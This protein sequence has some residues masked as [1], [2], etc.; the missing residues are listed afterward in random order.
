ML[1][2]TLL[3]I[4]LCISI[5]AYADDQNWTENSISVKQPNGISFSLANEIKYRSW[6]WN[7]GVFTKNWVFGVGKKLGNGFSI[8]LNYKQELTRS[9]TGNDVLERRPNFDISWKKGL[10][11]RSAFDLRLRTEI[12]KYDNGLKSDQY[13]FRF[14]FRFTVQ[15]SILGH[16]VEPYLA[17]EPFYDTTSDSLSKYRFSTGLTVPI[18]RHTKLRLGYLLE[19]AR[20]GP[21]HHVFTT[22][23]SLSF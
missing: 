11:N 18:I 13:R 5:S 15:R 10:S 19:E 1:R 7:D 6:N 17:I 23:V 21:T 22:G 20:R 9:S 16:S 3:L 2:K 12:R 14:R 8:S 4:F